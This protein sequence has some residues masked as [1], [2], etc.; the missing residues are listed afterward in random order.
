MSHEHEHE[1]EILSEEDKAF[2]REKFEK[3]MIGTVP[4]K[5]LVSDGCEYCHLMEDLLR[6]LADLSNGKIQL[7][8]EEINEEY[9]NKLKLDKGPVILIGE[10]EEIQY[11][12]SPLGEEGWAFLETIVLASN[13]KHGLED[14]ADKLKNL[15]KKVRIETIVTPSCPYCPHAVLMANRIAIASEGKVVSDCVE[16]YEFPEIADKWNVT[17]VPTIVLS[18]EEPY[19]GQVFVV[20]LPREKQLI[21]AVTKA[22]SGE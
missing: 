17:A 21:E 10:N 4:I 6:I 16:A 8:I 20:G 14:H 13:K 3:E 7:T 12:G 11:T 18:I 15:N 22:V 1:H 2:I 19:S 9:K 5:L